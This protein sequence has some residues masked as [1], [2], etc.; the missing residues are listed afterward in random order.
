MENVLAVSDTINAKETMTSVEIA[1]ITGKRHDSVLRDIDNL[2]EQGVS[3]HNF[4]ESNYTTDRGKTYRCFE[5][6]KKGCLILASGYDA[7]LR[8]KIINRWEQLETEKRNGGFVIPQTLSQALMLAAKQAEQI[9]QQQKLLEVQKPKVE[10]FDSVADSKTAVPMNDVAKVLSIKGYGR[11]NLFEYLR[12][13]KVLM[14]NN[15]PYQK[16]V[17]A[18]YFRVIEQHY[19]RNGEEQISFKTLVYQRGID[20]IRR[21]LNAA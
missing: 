14:N 3:L 8:E 13:N 11:N 16:Y 12:N 4:V 21:M 10:F 19:Q 5:L 15:R 2:L 20:F 17:D 7:V 1:E 9:E 18:G 6:T